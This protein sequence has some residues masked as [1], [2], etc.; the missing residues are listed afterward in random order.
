M[1]QES[2][3]TYSRRLSEASRT[4]VIVIM[5]DIILE[6]IADAKSA[7]TA[8][9]NEG[10]AASLGHG[11]KFVKEL[12]AVL[13]MSFD[14]SKD[15]ARL[16]IYVSGCLSRAKVSREAAELASAA[17]VI[18]GLRSAFAEVA[19]KDTEGAVMENTQ[20]VYAGLTYGR[21]ALNE[22]TVSPDERN[23]GFLA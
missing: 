12:T 7:F 23:R 8:G 18:T 20:K 21:G 16:Y 19:K 15:L 4:E 10:A 9:D 17:E 2:I 11:L 5:Y 1:K 22:T 6:D 13:D 3:M 14:M